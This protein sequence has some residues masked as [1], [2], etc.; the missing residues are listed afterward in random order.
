M[1]NW[2]AIYGHLFRVSC[3]VRNVGTELSRLFS[4]PHTLN[5]LCYSSI[6]PGPDWLRHKAHYFLLGV[7]LLPK[8]FGNFHGK[9]H[10][11]MN[12]YHLKLVRF[13][14]LFG[15]NYIDRGTDVA[16]NSLELVNPR[17]NSSYTENKED[18]FYTKVS[19]QPAGQSLIHPL[20]E[21][22]EHNLSQN[23]PIKGCSRPLGSKSSL[24]LYLDYT[25]P[26]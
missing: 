22:F 19:I 13:V 17:Q 7:F 24:A 18:L 15:Q 8:S 11:L 14:S 6:C 23:S 21:P 4:S 20:L 10:R 5:C 25:G 12:V 2:S 16:V 1:L 26:D 3:H 9:V